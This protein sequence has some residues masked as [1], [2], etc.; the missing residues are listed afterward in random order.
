MYFA[1]R[2]FLHTREKPLILEKPF[3]FRSGG[4]VIIVWAVY[5]LYENVTKHLDDLEY[6]K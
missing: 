2:V 4:Q 6:L 5:P 3:S 1:F